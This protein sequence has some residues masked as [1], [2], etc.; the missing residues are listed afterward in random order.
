MLNIGPPELL[1]ILVIALVVVGPQ[2]LPELG[3]TIGRGLRELR[4]VQDDVRDMVNTGL[5]DDLKETAAELK[6]SASDLRNATDI[7]SAFRNT[8]HQARQR[9]AAAVTG[10]VTP[11]D[12]P[13]EPDVAPPSPNGDGPPEDASRDPGPADTP[14]D[15]ASDGPADRGPGEPDGEP[16]L[17]SG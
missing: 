1:L 6:R 11:D 16:E 17:D 13:S 15:R 2:R 8:P 5:D 4:K 7:R 3:R 14:A 10:A 12:G 9:A